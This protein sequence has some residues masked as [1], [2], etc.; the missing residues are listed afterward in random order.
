MQ[1]LTK[2]NRLEY[3]ACAA[4][5]KKLKDWTESENNQLSAEEKK[6]LKTA[7]TYMRKACI[8]VLGRLGK[9]V[10]ERLLREAKNSEFTVIPYRE[11]H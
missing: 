6:W 7:S 11:V 5:V 4:M 3:L 2:K 8:S 1:Y 9:D 10:A